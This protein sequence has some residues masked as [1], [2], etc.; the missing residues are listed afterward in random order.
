[1]ISIKKILYVLFFAIVAQPVNAENSFK[2]ELKKYKPYVLPTLTVGTAILL[3]SPHVRGAVKG[4]TEGIGELWKSG[5]TTP[6]EALATLGALS[7]T[8]AIM[9]A[10]VSIPVSMVMWGSILSYKSVKSQYSHDE[11]KNNIVKRVDIYP[12]PLALGGLLVY[13]G[14][15]IGSKLI[16]N[17]GAIY[18]GILTTVFPLFS[19]SLS[20]N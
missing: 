3:G 20:E 19:K 11:Q 4:M 8:G 7:I 5:C 16:N 1:M 13:G 2:E 12:A 6:N 9:G 17:C 15:H 10:I 18:E 14:A